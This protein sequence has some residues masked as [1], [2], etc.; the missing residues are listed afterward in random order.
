MKRWFERSELVYIGLL[1]VFALGLFCM[2]FFT[3][4]KG[5][6]DGLNPV[7]Q[8][9]ILNLGVYFLIYFLFRAVALKK[10]LGTLV[11]GSLGAMTGVMSLDVLLPEYHVSVTGELIKGGIF[12]ASASDYFFGYLGSLIHIHGFWLWAWTYLLM[13]GLLIMATAL[14][15]R[16]F[17]KKL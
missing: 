6:I 14:L 7:L 4:A 3:N 10:K 2:L 8:F 1:V 16:N 13:A 5:F 17:V 9:L 15:E 12:G 11:V